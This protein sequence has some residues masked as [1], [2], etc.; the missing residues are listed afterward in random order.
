V[1]EGPEAGAARLFADQFGR[2]P[3]GV[4]QAPGRVNLI[5]GHTD[6]NDGFALPFAIGS[7]V[8][9]AASAR[10]DGRLVLVSAQEDAVVTADV[11][12]PVIGWAA[13]PAG[14]VWAMRTAGFPVGGASIAVDAS[15]APGAGLSSSA[16]L[17]C[18]VALA[19][20]DLY[21]LSLTRPELARLARRAENEFV[22]A[23]TGIMDQLAVLLSRAGHALLLDCRPPTVPSYRSTRRPRD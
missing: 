5:G 4:W 6:Y 11:D 2:A 13:Y 22:G 20:A 17:E 3:D 14:V 15:L 9:V 16:A 8:C 12:E 10:P 1:P 23:P 7:R 18:A 21:S 19:L